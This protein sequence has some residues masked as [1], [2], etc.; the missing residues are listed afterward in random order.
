MNFTI[1]NVFQGY[2][3]TK[4]IDTSGSVS[5]LKMRRPI[6]ISSLVSPFEAGHP[7]IGILNAILIFHG[8]W[9]SYLNIKFTMGVQKMQ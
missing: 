5:T 8:S 4:I 2:K 3:I 1:G 7:I 6:D 9:V